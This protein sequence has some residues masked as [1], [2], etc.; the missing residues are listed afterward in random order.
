MSSKP[1][2]GSSSYPGH[3]F[4]VKTSPGVQKTRSNVGKAK[5]RGANLSKRDVSYSPLYLTSSWTPRDLSNVQEYSYD[6]DHYLTPLCMN[7][8]RIQK[9]TREPTSK[10]SQD[11][12]K[13]SRDGGRRVVKSS[14]RE[15]S[16]KDS[17]NKK[18]S[19][20]KGKRGR[21]S[22]QEEIMSNPALDAQVD[23]ILSFM[24]ENNW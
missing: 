23:S 19:T 7:L 1:K 12:I 9:H 8:L 21:K 4:G 10:T 13:R 16:T 18:D 24:Q 3:K 15:A 14:V 20:T 11:V 5:N 2:F 22:T 6:P 17:T